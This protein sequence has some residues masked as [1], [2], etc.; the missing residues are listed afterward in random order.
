MAT[1]A[2]IKHIEKFNEYYKKH[3]G[4]LWLD[5]NSEYYVTKAYNDR[6][7]H[8]LNIVNSE[9]PDCILD[10]GC[11]RG[12]LSILVNNGKRV[13]KGIEPALNNAYKYK[14]NTGN[15][16]FTDIAEN[17]WHIENNSFSMAIMADVIE[18]VLQPQKAIEEALRIL[19]INGILIITTPNKLAEDLWSIGK[20]PSFHKLPVYERLF[21]PYELKHLVKH[22]PYKINYS[23]WN[24]NGVY[25]RSK[26]LIKIF[27]HKNKLAQRF[28]KF[29]DKVEFLRYR[30]IMVIRKLGDK[31]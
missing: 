19:K 7:Q 2:Q 27:N 13:I 8:I 11:G 23:L 17:M 31:K 20:K 14:S 15:E 26:I 12:D 25:P 5:G 28:I 29:C 22:I 18:H 4:W 24:M 9:N 21:D 30:Q 10:I 6:N 16:V 1:K 3:D